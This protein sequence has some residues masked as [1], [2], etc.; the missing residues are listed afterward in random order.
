MAKYLTI[1]LTLSD[2]PSN[3]KKKYR[4]RIEQSPCGASKGSGNDF[5]LPGE[6]PDDFPGFLEEMQ[7]SGSLNKVTPEELGKKLFNAVF[8]GDVRMKYQECIAIADN[9][10]TRVRLMLSI[11][12]PDLIQIPWEFFHDGKSFLSLRQGGYSIVRVIDDIPDQTKALKP[13]QNPLIAI[14]LPGDD[15]TKKHIADIKDKFKKIGIN[16][17]IVLEN[18]TRFKLEETIKEKPFDAFYFIGHGKFSSTT[19]GQL[20]LVSEDGN[21]NEYLGADILANWL[22]NAPAPNNGRFVY[23]N[24]CSTAVASPGNTFAGVAQRLITDGKVSTVVAMQ[25]PISAS[26]AFRMA[27][28]FLEQIYDGNSPERALVYCRTNATRDYS[29]GIPVLYSQNS[30]LDSFENNRIATLLDADIGRSHFVLSLPIFQM[31]ILPEDYSKIKSKILD[32][33]LG[34]VFK[35]KE[36]TLAKRDFMSA[37]YILQL[38]TKITDLNH[39]EIVDANSEPNLNATHIFYFGSRSHNQV[40]CVQQNYPVFFKF[41][42]KKKNIW[43]IECLKN[44]KKYEL[45]KKVPNQDDYGVIEKIVDKTNNHI[46]F[47]IAGLSDKATEGCGYYFFTHWKEIIKEYIKGSFGILLKFPAGLGFNDASIQEQT[48]EIKIGSDNK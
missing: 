37:H 40:H 44:H 18:V 32:I 23:L 22:A 42:T 16:D 4:A 21:T 7:K 3:D 30:S 25:A 38:I 41:Q 5:E 29:W 24:S 31:G 20:S 33:S 27:S 14:A 43:W 1:K 26:E 15:K 47:I 36:K 10:N 12:S 39:V 34:N 8:Q 48:G 9:N 11:F 13:F 17:P 6:L 46:Y 35:Y 2:L 19:G 28:S 45:N